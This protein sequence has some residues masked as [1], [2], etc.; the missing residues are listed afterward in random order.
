MNGIR[1]LEDLDID[2]RIIFKW[3]LKK[4][5]ERMKSYWINLAQDRDQ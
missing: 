4:Y 2:G 1:H 5:S 3:L